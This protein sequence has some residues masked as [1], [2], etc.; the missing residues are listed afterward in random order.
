MSLSLG[1]TGIFGRLRVN[2]N[3]F[4]NSET[5]YTM[6]V[7]PIMINAVERTPVGLNKATS[8]AISMSHRN[9]VKSDPAQASSDGQ[10]KAMQSAAH[11][12][13]QG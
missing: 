13:V 5:A 8:P 1:A 12:P 11:H 6:L 10:Q 9:D 2:V 4:V 3:Q 7:I